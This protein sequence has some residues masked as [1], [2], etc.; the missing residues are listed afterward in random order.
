MET[1]T[2]SIAAHQERIATIYG[3]INERHTWEYMFS[4]L[5]RSVGYLWK[6]ISDARVT[7]QELIRPLSWILALAVKLEIGLQDAFCRR[8]PAK[9]PYCVATPCVCLISGKRP[10]NNTATHKV[11]GILYKAHSKLKDSPKSRGLRFAAATIEAIYPQNLAVWRFA[12]PSF[13]IT[14][15][16]EEMA[17][18]HEAIALY[19]V[20]KRRKE[21]V[22]EELADVF[23][24]TVGTWR[25]ALP[26]NNMDDEFID[27]Y[28]KGCPVCL[29]SSCKCRDYSGRPT[30]LINFEI[31]RELEESMVE[32]SRRSGRGDGKSDELRSLRRAIETENEPTANNAL[33]DAIKWLD[34]VSMVEKSPEIQALVK[35]ARR[36]AR[37]ANP[38][39]T[40]ALPER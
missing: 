1:T 10:K 7:S 35:K 27:Y 30:G 34:D 16:L 18:V 22:S 14:K 33:L 25:L 39:S 24:W 29:A 12:G 19:R 17:E 37:E 15:L 8:Y 40:G 6:S 11:Q 32:I 9:C 38:L 23:A 13:R 2:P 36:R 31:L 20:G 21:A 4:Y 5:G 3:A 28:Y 26:N